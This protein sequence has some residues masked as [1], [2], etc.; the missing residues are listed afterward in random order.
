MTGARMNPICFMP[1]K[2]SI[3]KTLL[4]SIAGIAF[5]AFFSSCKNEGKNTESVPVDSA[6]THHEEPITPT[7]DGAYYNDLARFLAGLMPQ[8]D[9]GLIKL[10]K[11]SVWIRFSREMNQGFVNIEQNRFKAMHAWRD[12]EM[13]D[14]PKLGTKTLFYPLSGP[15]F[16]NAWNLFPSQQNFILVALE[17]VGTLKNPVTMNSENLTHYLSSVSGSLVD[18][19]KRS[20]FI[21]KR[22]SGDF[23]K[24]KIDGNLPVLMVFLART[25]QQ[26]TS[27]N[28]ILIDSTGKLTAHSL[29][30]SLPKKALNK[31]VRITFIPKGETTPRTLYYIT[32]NLG[33][34]EYNSMPGLDVNKGF[35]IWV[36]SFGS[37]VSYCKAASYLLHYG[38]FSR[39]RNLV[40]NHS[41]LHLQDDSGIGFSYFK[42]DAWNISLYGR[43]TRPIA[44]F[45]KIF[46]KDLAAAYQE[47]SAHVKPVPFILGYHWGAGRENMNLLIARRK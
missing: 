36:E 37:T 43:Y 41:K 45:S 7:Q 13:G 46:E 38:T 14:V 5:M 27:I 1:L 6:K 8:Q 17:P 28:R 11:D 21:T 42:K 9:A 44:E 18:I 26:I 32:T 35:P 2:L 23:S 40:L 16:L 15:D 20:Y 29:H 24:W 30:D 33:D 47:D 25:G 34:Q 4:Y 39:A 10:S 22:M 19:F 12:A 3:N 31:G